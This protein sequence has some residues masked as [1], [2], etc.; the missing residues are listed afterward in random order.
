M[1]IIDRIEIYYKTLPF[2][3]KTFIIFFNYNFLIYYKKGFFL[4]KYYNTNNP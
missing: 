3:K 2:E 1:P 4:S